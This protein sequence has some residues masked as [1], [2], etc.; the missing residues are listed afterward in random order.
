MADN[1]LENHYA[2]YQA[3]KAMQKNRLSKHASSTAI[4]SLVAPVY[5]RCVDEHALLSFYSELFDT[6]EV[7]SG[8]DEFYGS[9]FI[10]LSSSLAGVNLRFIHYSSQKLENIVNQSPDFAIKMRSAYQMRSLFS[11]LTALSVNII[12]YS[13]D[14]DGNFIRVIFSDLEGNIVEVLK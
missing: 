12:F 11:R 13:E 7:S 5:I 3:R 9:D 4:A 1:Y 14:K 8:Y 2:E 6:C 10:S